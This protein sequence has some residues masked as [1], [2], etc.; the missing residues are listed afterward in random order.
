MRTS[1]KDHPGVL[2][3]VGEIVAKYLKRRRQNREFL[4][5]TVPGISEMLE[6]ISDNVLTLVRK[7][8]EDAVEAIQLYLDALKE[9]D[10]T[11][12]SALHCAEDK[13]S[14]KQ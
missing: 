9:I 7:G 12:R 2:N 4:S 11:L 3:E 14:K 8:D 10:S 1:K 5:S 13:L 6:D